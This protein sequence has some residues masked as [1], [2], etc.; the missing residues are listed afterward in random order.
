MPARKTG[1]HPEAAAAGTLT[2]DPLVKFT[3]GNVAVDGGP[4]DTELTV[5]VVQPMGGTDTLTVTTDAAGHADITVTAN[6]AGMLTVTVSEVQT[7]EVAA[8]EVDV[9][10]SPYPEGDTG[11][12]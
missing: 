5:T 2:F 6:G 7:V 3:P 9:S 10:G 12:Q 8:G 11:G 4:P 1:D